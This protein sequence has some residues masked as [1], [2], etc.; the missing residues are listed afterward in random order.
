[1]KI[2]IDGT[3]NFNKGAEL[4]LLSI[5]Q[6][7]RENW[8]GEIELY[9]GRGIFSNKRLN[10]IGIKKFKFPSKLLQ[11]FYTIPFFKINSR[12]KID[13]VLDAS[14]FR[15]S[16]Y[17]DT[18]KTYY[19]IFLEYLYYNYL[20][21]SGTK[22]FFLPQAFGPFNSSKAK[23]K[24]K[25]ASRSAT[26]V[27]A[28][29]KESQKYLINNKNV[30]NSKILLLPDFTNLLSPKSVNKN[31]GVCIIPSSRMLSSIDKHEKGL[32]KEFLFAAVNYFISANK[33]VFILNHSN[34]E[35]N[36]IC[37]DL[38]QKFEDENNLKLVEIADTFELKNFIGSTDFVISSR[39]HGLINALSQNVPVLCIGW[40]HKYRYLLKDYL[41][42]DAIL[43][44]TSIDEMLKKLQ[45]IFNHGEL[46]NRVETIS[47][48]NEIQKTQ[49]KKMWALIKKKTYI[50][51]AE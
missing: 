36:E 47:I 44:I 2:V 50:T 15:F 46:E 29:D 11:L 38:Y 5:I 39:Y 43:E 7:I 18:Q 9:V 33:N 1:M 22:L 41:Q 23:L 40:T 13:L 28:R 6:E 24:L 8:E 20:A 17:W 31:Q 10:E 3:G 51:D 4:M 19:R 42:E 35:D 32:Y 27:F 37:S 45:S 26:L 25:F 49:A 12:F 14:G 48:Q 30:D 21:R 34:K 16:D